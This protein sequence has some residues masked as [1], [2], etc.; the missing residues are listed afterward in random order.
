MVLLAIAAGSLGA[1]GFIQ[2]VSESKRRDPDNERFGG[3]SEALS[4]LGPMKDGESYLRRA[5]DVMRKAIGHSL[6]PMALVQASTPSPDDAFVRA[7]V[8]KILEMVI[9]IQ[10]AYPQAEPMLALSIVEV[11]LLLE[12]HPYWLANLINFE[13]NKSFSSSVKNP[14]TNAVGLIQFLPSTAAGLLGMTPG[15]SRGRYTSAQR[16]E[17]VSIFESMPEVEQ[18][19]FVFDYLGQFG[20]LNTQQRLYMSVF[21]PVAMRWPKDKLFPEDVRAVNQAETPGQYIAYADRNARIRNPR[22][23]IAVA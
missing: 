22:E 15:R 17:A 20:K 16:E 5:L 19:S 7:G 10:Q 14:H 3:F 1:A 6:E 13:S 21:Y 11:A 4:Q 8:E 23:N 9:E 2:A 12:T 18:M